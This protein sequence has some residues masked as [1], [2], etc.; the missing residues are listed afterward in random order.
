MS[1]PSGERAGVGAAS[2]PES[3]R[4]LTSGKR[5]APPRRYARSHVT[6]GPPLPL[7]V[8]PNDETTMLTA[9][10][11][12]TISGSPLLWM[13][14]AMCAFVA[15]A[16]AYLNF[17]VIGEERRVRDNGE[18]AEARIVRLW[19]EEDRR[20]K[21]TKR[22]LSY[23]HLAWRGKSGADMEVARLG[24]AGETYTALRDAEARGRKTTPIHYDPTGRNT[25]PFLVADS[26]PRESQWALMQK[27]MWGFAI[28]AAVLAWL[29]AR[30]NRA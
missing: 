18:L 4:G 19:Q 21:S 25:T 22:M 23:V 9:T 26:V 20:S 17:F 1:L 16:F 29:V 8:M 30:R 28:L 15:L 11:S 3:P 12:R 14:P 7:R 10:R 27:V 13:L 24:I 2:S 5:L 6:S